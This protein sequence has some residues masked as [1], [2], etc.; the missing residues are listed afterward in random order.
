[1]DNLYVDAQFSDMPN[2]DD[3]ALGTL[4]DGETK[5]GSLSGNGGSVDDFEEQLFETNNTNVPYSPETFLLDPG[6]S[7][8]F[9]LYVKTTG[10]SSV[11]IDVD[12][13]ANAALADRI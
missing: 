2:D 3:G 13:K 12:I 11:D 8:D 4:A 1:V 9:G 7:F 5:F 10:D 6:Q